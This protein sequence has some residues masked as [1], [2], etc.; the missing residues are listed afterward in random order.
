MRPSHGRSAGLPRTNAAARA[1]AGRAPGGRSRS[2]DPGRA[3]PSANQRNGARSSWPSARRA[4]PVQRPRARAP[5]ASQLS[6]ARSSWPSA[7]RAVPVQRPRARTAAANQRSGA[8]S[9]WPSARRAAPVQRPKARTRRGEPAQRHAQ[10]LAE[11]PESGPDPTT[12]GTH[13]RVGEP[14]RRHAQ[15]LAERPKSGPGPTTQGT[16]RRGEPAQRHAEGSSQGAQRG[17]SPAQW[18]TQ[19][20]ARHTPHRGDESP[21]A[22]A[23]RAEHVANP[24]P[25]RP[26]EIP[27]QHERKHRHS[28]DDL[29]P[30]GRGW[31]LVVHERGVCPT[32]GGGV[33]DPVRRPRRPG[34]SCCSCL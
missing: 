24:A 13:R 12:Q 17:D 30:R 21:Q 20:P 32:G 31:L 5:A 10:Q 14:A 19:D 34:F 1:A 9:S 3:A 11:R 15:Q 28:E 29:E 7:R 8:R 18:R 22:R 27:G 2:N 25:Q 6:G 23:D 26:E 4:V 33:V 16:H